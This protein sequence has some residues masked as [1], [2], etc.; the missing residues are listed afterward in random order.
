MIKPALFVYSIENLYKRK[1]RSWL[2]ILSVLIG[3]AS[4]TA[5]MSFGYGISNYV[6]DMSKQMGNDKLIIME[7]GMGGMGDKPAF[8][9]EDLEVI[10]KANGVGEATG[11]NVISA[12]IEFGK[13]KK[14]TMLAGVD[15]KKHKILIEEIMTV[16]I[17]AGEDLK[18]D[19][20]NKAIFGYNYM[21][22]DKVFTKALKVGDKITVNGKEISVGGFYGEIGNPADDANIYITEKC[23]EE[24]FGSLG[25]YEIVAR[26]TPG[27]NA[28]QIAEYVT[29]DLRNHRNQKEGQEDFFVQTFEQIIATFNTVLG[30]IIGVVMLIAVI[31]VIVASVNIMNTMYASI[32]D[33]TKEIGI[34]KAI[35]A[36]NSEILMIFVTES[37]VL[38]IIG[39]IL[40][41]LIGMGIAKVGGIAI[42][43]A[44]YAAF[45]PY[46]SL[47]IISSIM[48][49][50]L[51]IGIAAGLLPS[52][53]ASKLK[54]VDTLRYE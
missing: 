3:I 38:S 2:T 27:S 52:Y 32:I 43:S 21:L 54:P 37:S 30:V 25:Y 23:A 39:G 51:V 11:M 10:E 34:F 42:A 29:K 20:K 6:Q 46:F 28:T 19:E 9:K 12:E 45:Q 18:G 7:K 22:A 36:K 53:Q 24:V 40:G 47:Q 8:S 49:F 26:V 17:I 4:I 14:Y 35:G 31:S 41:V 5:L 50:S 33:R 16:E 1:T 13:Q 48:L 44:G 15:Y